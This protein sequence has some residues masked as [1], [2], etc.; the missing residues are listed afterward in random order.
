[1][2]WSHSTVTNSQ[3]QLFVLI[4]DV[5]YFSIRFGIFNFTVKMCIALIE[6][7]NL[8]R[9]NVAAFFDR[10]W[11]LFPI[12]IQ[13]S[14][15]NIIMISKKKHPFKCAKKITNTFTF[16]FIDLVYSIE[17]IKSDEQSDNVR[18]L[19]SFKYSTNSKFSGTNWHSRNNSLDVNMSTSFVIL[20]FF[21]NS[22]FRDNLISIVF[23][24]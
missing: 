23:F 9:K 18:N 24:T 3:K 19:V 4:Y 10:K 1:M 22:R 13:I 7:K 17:L 15:R 11:M 14:N 6:S 2:Q 12:C 8:S 21:I 20:D 16:E 5:F